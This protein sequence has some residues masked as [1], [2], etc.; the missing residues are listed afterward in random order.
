MR[1]VLEA[2]AKQRK[3]FEE[4]ASSG[5][6]IAY[7]EGGATDGVAVSAFTSRPPQSAIVAR[8]PVSTWKLEGVNPRAKGK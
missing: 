8:A 6:E 7:G 1:D 5:I 2:W 4:L 3:T